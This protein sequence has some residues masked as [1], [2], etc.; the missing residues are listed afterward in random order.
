M[1]ALRQVVIEALYELESSSHPADEVLDRRLLEVG[2]EDRRIAGDAAKNYAFEM[3]TGVLDT[4]DESDQYIGLAASKYP[5]SSMAVI[6]RNILRLA[7]WE[8]LTDD[9]A[10]VA[11]VI[12]EAVELAH[13]YGGDSSPGFI[14]GVLRTVSQDIRKHGRGHLPPVQVQEDDPTDQEN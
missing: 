12:N 5:V 8:L 3:L 1:R 6:D 9:S 7:I 11:A 13:R 10:P 14:N 2:D 4:Q